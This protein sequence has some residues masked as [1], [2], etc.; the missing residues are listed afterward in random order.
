MCSFLAITSKQTTPKLP[1]GKVQR[2]GVCISN[3]ALQQVGYTRCH[4]RIN[5]RKRAPTVSNIGL[6]CEVASSSS[7][8]K[9]NRL[10]KCEES[11]L[12]NPSACHCVCLAAYMPACMCACLHVCLPPCILINPPVHIRCGRGYA[13]ASVGRVHVAW[14]ANHLSW[15]ERGTLYETQQAKVTQL[16]LGAYTGGRA[17]RV[18]A[19]VICWIPFKTTMAKTQSTYCTNALF[20]RH[21]TMRLRLKMLYSSSMSIALSS[22]TATS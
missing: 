7:M 16:G 1:S 11:K 17:G 20:S 15:F 22:R 21:H 4:Q 8:R 9:K 18:K 13:C 14:C 10:S 2:H 6:T 5:W 12:R 3:A 19:S